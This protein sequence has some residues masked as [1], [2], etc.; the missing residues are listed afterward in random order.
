MHSF[1]IRRRKYYNVTVLHIP[2]T[3]RAADKQTLS[4]TATGFLSGLVVDEKT[5]GDA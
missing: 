4:G 1:S 2:Q 5:W 3:I